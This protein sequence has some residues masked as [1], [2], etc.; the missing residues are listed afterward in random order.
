MYIGSIVVINVS[1]VSG[2]RAALC[3]IALL[4]GQTATLS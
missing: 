2:G 4:G 3:G 1:Q